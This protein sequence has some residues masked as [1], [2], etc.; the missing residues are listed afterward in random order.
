MTPIEALQAIAKE[1]DREL[2]ENAG[3]FE[4]RGQSIRWMRKLAKDA[5]ATAKP[6]PVSDLVRRLNMMSDPLSGEAADALDRQAAEI[7]ELRAALAKAAR[8]LEEAADDVAGWGA[9]AGEYFARKHDLDGSVGTIR[10][11]AGAARR[12]AEKEG[13]G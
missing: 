5:L 11:N 9:Y 2:G 13:Q 12:L 4:T 1:A 6:A 8:D 7:A 3:V 10:S